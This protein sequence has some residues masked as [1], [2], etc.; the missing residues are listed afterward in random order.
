MA[1]EPL[2]WN[3]VVPSLPYWLLK[4]LSG[5]NV[6]SKV[7]NFIT[8]SIF[9]TFLLP[10]TFFK[11][12]IK[13]ES[14][15]STIANRF[16]QKKTSSTLV[17]IFIWQQLTILD[18]YKWQGHSA[19]SEVTQENLSSEVGSFIEYWYYCTHI[20]LKIMRI[21]AHLSFGETLTCTV[22][23]SPSLQNLCWKWDFFFPLMVFSCFSKQFGSVL[24]H[25]CIFKL[26]GQEWL[27]MKIILCK[28]PSL[29]VSDG[30]NS[31]WFYVMF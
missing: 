29:A 9:T 8:R 25:I 16:F 7:L 12:C 23:P 10:N 5:L 13:V 18:Y 1:S 31:I 30:V 2:P 3:S 6:K 14:V 11:G 22:L 28:S 19:T 26:K 17:W 4:S 24:Q 27:E 20:L 21:Q 15:W